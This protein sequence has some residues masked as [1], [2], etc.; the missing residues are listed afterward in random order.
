MYFCLSDPEEGDEDV[1]EAGG[2]LRE[3]KAALG[4]S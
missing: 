1:H 3:Q 2:A 4:A